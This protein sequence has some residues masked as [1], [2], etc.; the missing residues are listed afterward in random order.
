[1]G[2]P[3]STGVIVEKLLTIFAYRVLESE[4]RDKL[5]NEIIDIGMSSSKQ[6]V[7]SAA[8]CLSFFCRSLTEFYSLIYF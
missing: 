2:L 3:D 6:V 5:R 4:A 8:V 1:M 7:S